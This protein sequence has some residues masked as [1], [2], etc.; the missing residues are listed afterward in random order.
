ME[1]KRCL[2]YRTK[3]EPIYTFK[4]RIGICALKDGTFD[5]ECRCDGYMDN[6][7]FLRQVGQ[8]AQWRFGG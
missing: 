1:I 8:Y 5:N 4:K 2:Y 6:C 7:D 3:N